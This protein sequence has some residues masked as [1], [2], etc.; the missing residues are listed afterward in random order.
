LVVTE[1]AECGSLKSILD[2]ICYEVGYS[3]LR[4]IA[5][6]P[7]VI[8]LMNFAHQTASGMAFLESKNV[9]DTDLF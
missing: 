1:F 2:S 9:S 3:M 6:Q 8:D 5:I 7:R 4:D